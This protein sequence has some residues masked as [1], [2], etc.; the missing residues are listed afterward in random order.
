MDQARVRFEQY[1]KRRFGQSSTLKHYISD[2]NIFIDAID[3]K[4]PERVTAEDID[5][6]VDQQIAARLSP[7]TINRRLASLHTF[8][9]YLA[10]EKPERDWPN[11]VIQSSTLCSMIFTIWVLNSFSGN[12]L[13]LLQ[14]TSWRLILLTSPMWKVPR[15]SLAIW[16]RNSTD[17]GNF[18]NQT[19][20]FC[21]L[22]H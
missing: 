5:T 15:S 11:P 4:A 14:A 9:E 2:L 6:F 20:H 10:S 16:F 1:L 12:L 3:N 7:A 8:F 13:Q 22:T 19:T 17:L 18:P 21:P